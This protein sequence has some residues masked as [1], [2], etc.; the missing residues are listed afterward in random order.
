MNYKTAYNKINQNGVIDEIINRE[1]ANGANLD[2]VKYHI[3]EGINYYIEFTKSSTFKGMTY[4][5]ETRW[6]VTDGQK[7]HRRIVNAVCKA[8]A[9]IE[10][11]ECAAYVKQ[12]QYMIDV[13][14]RSEIK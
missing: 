4:W 12:L 11:E 9:Q 2:M 8:L 13:S 3:I 6:L 1:V 7:L 5:H 14:G 10:I